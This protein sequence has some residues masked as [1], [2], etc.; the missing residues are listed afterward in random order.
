MARTIRYRAIAEALRAR[1]DAGEFAAGR[2][3]PSEAEL[4]ATYE[5]S[6]VTVRRALEVLR[7]DG[8]ID[9]RQGFGW[10]VATDPQ[11]LPLDRLGTIEAELAEAD[12]DNERHILAFGFGAAPGWVAEHLGPGSVLEVRRV[13]LADGA[14]F[15]RVTVWCPEAL[16]ADLSRAAVE[17][18]PFSEALGLD[19]GGATQT[20]SAKAAS[21]ADAEVLEVPEG[22]PVL[23]CR[24]VTVDVEGAKVLVSEHVYPGHLT[25]FVVDLRSANT[26]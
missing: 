20:I 9:S 18:S 3:L 5:A 1:L 21:A 12:R 15:A 26:I 22:S 10:F 17:R 4:S 11:R 2:V 8:L 6:R 16:G 24:R 13:N 23:E 19:F 14:P 25:E 7:S